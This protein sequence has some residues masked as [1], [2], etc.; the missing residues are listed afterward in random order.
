MSNRRLLSGYVAAIL[1][2]AVTRYILHQRGRL[3]PSSV[4]LTDSAKSVARR[5]FG[6]ADLSRVRVVVTDPI[7]ISDPPLAAFVR[8]VGFDFPSVALSEAITFDYII[9]CREP[10]TPSLLST[11]WCMSSNT[12]S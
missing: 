9:A 4:A 11:S 6:E 8:R 5:Y 7:P 12:G 3:A 10:M 1:S 2:P